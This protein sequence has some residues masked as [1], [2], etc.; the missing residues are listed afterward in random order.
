VAEEMASGSR[1]AMECKV[2]SEWSSVNRIPVHPLQIGQIVTSEESLPSTGALIELSGS[3]PDDFPNSVGR[4]VIS[5]F[6]LL[7][8]RV[9]DVPKRF[10]NNDDDRR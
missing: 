9:A 6:A 2:I 3:S 5:T 4:H 10:T 8:R 1:A 7:F